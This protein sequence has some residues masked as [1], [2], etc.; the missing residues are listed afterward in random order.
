MVT[1]AY[2]NHTLKL[3]TELTKTYPHFKWHI[4][5]REYLPAE[6]DHEQN[7]VVRAKIR[8]NDIE[9]FVQVLV[10][11]EIAYEMF[12][13]ALAM[14]IDSVGLHTIAYICEKAQ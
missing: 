14:I 2:Y 8:I 11:A 10:K 7:F 4:L 5:G 12:D 3:E 1:R 9:Y 13:R 6:A